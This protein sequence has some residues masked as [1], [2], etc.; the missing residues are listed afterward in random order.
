MPELPEVE[1]IAKNLREGCGSPPIPGQ[2]II[3]FS[4]DWP[5]HVGHPSLRTFKRRI[6]NREIVAVKRRGKYLVF[7]LDQDTLLIHLRMS[8]DLRLVPS[9]DPKDRFDHTIFGLDNDWDL[10]FSDAR[11][12]GRVGLYTD[13]EVVLGR[14]GPE[15]L[16][17]DFTY[18]QFAN[19]LHGRKRILKPLLLDQSFLAGMG[20]I[21]TDEALHQAR[22]HPIRRS[23]S[24]TNAEV[25]RLWRSI[26]ESL[27]MGIHHNGASIDW[28]FRGGDFQHHFRVYKR[29]GEPCFKCGAQIQ[30]TVVGGRGTH[31]CP[32]CQPED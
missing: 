28:V 19:M 14:L 15:P 2:R 18:D 12:F 25:K 27:E 9:Q 30:R 7:P 8:G 1:T 32:R 23:D 20:N 22:V 29:E 13:P 31:F 11:K 5:R 10:R 26:R 3:R 17:P 21:Y 4:T 6:K 16:A 24:L